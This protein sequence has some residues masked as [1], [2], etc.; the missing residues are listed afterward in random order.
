VFGKLYTIVDSRPNINILNIVSK[1]Y[2]LIRFSI[3]KPVCC[4]IF[5]DQATIKPIIGLYIDY[6]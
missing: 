4:N 3:D 1:W 2:C 5:K 6:F